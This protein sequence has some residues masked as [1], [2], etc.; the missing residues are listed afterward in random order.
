M[1]YN[2]SNL[3]IL[4]RFHKLGV[5]ADGSSLGCLMFEAVE[6]DKAGGRG[7]ET[8]HQNR[9]SG[10]LYRIGKRACTLLK[11]LHPTGNKAKVYVGLR[12]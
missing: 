12:H 1:F 5:D 9:T 10:C 2:I 8:Y 4:L 7:R 3:Y 11:Q 6:D